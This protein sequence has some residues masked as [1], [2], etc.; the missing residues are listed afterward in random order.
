MDMI[1][2]ALAKS[3]TDKT[4][5]E[6]GLKGKSAYEYAVEAGYKGSEEEFE[7][8]MLA[9]ASYADRLIALEQKLSNL[10]YNQNTDTYILQANLDIDGQLTEKN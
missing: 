10:N 3:Y 6:T 8:S 2:Y 4:V 9:V 7:Q 5:T 1:T